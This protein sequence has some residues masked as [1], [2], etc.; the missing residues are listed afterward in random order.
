[1]TDTHDDWRDLNEPPTPGKIAQS[2]DARIAKEDAAD[3]ARSSQMRSYQIYRRAGLRPLCA[4]RF[5]L[6]HEAQLF[7]HRLV[8]R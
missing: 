5:M 4:V 6:Q 3:N 8:T 7:F 2:E 1:M